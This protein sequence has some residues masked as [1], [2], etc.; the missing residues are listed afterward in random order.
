M[1][2]LVS[3]TFQPAPNP[4][5]AQTQAPREAGRGHVLVIGN[6]KGG[7]GKSTTALHIAVSL[8]S[9]GARVATLDLDARQGT[10]S[11]YLENRAAYAKRKGVD[12]PMPMHTPVPISIFF[13]RAPTAASS[14]KGEASCRAKWWTRK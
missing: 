1:S 4:S 5:V 13:V 7:S 8:M 9:D 2:S 10:L 14:G 6:E 11:R 3:D 12:L